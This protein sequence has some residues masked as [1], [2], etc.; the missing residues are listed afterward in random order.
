MAGQQSE[1]ADAAG[2]QSPAI[3]GGN[4]DAPP[5]ADA[6]MPDAASAGAPS[7]SCVFLTRALSLS[8]ALSPPHPLVLSLSLSHAASAGAPSLSCVFKL[9]PFEPSLEA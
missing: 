4:A 9:L 3:S 6:A 5:A 2:R 8:R 1:I 7:L